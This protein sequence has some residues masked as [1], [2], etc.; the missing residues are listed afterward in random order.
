MKQVIGLTGG[1]ASGKSTVSAYLRELGLAVIDADALV[2]DLQRKGGPLY[3][4]LVD[5]LGQ[6]ILQEDGQL[7]R[8][9][10]GA[11]LFGSKEMLEKSAEL[12]NPIIRRELKVALEEKLA[13]QDL[14]FLDIPLLYEQ[15]YEDWCD[16]VWVVYVDQ[17]T[18]IK[19][20]MGRNSLTTEEAQLRISRQLSLEDKRIRADLV[21]D[22]RGSLENLKE[23]VQKGLQGL[24]IR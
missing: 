4:V 21:L 12:Q 2:H 11:L 15:G 20:L 6:D 1:I 24:G 8:K 5:W 13:E 23:Q 17:T 3:Q 22:N 18:Q 7:D 16:Q 10:L 14:V 9:A 19:R